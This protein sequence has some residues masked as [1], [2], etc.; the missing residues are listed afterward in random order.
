MGA[1]LSL[2][3]AVGVPLGGGM[4]MGMMTKDEIKGWYAKLNK[5][6]WNPPNKLFGPAWA[7]FYAS[8]G[9]ASWVTAR[10]GV[11]RFP[12][13][14]LYG[15]QLALNLAWTPIMFKWHKV[16]VALADSAAMLGVAAAATVSMAQSTNRPGTI[17]P[18]MVPYLC[19]VTFATA[20]T[21][22]ILRLNP[23]ETLD[24]SCVRKK[25]S[26]TKAKVVDTGKQAVASVA[27]AS[28]K[29]AATVKQTTEQVAAKASDAVG[30]VARKAQEDAS[31]LKQMV[32]EA[33]STAADAAKPMTS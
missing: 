24:Y 4:A 5:P 26:D 27:E 8:M 29:A 20:L 21:G 3:A 33:V 14:V 22:E 11:N 13:L 32:G 31:A 7:V 10:K 23:S 17:L 15:V 6:K 9:L 12:P 16:D 1:A 28:Q 19:W 18:L 2:V 30:E 25:A